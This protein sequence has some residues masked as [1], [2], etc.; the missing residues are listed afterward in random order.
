MIK[1]CIGILEYFCSVSGI[2]IHIPFCKQQCHYCDF[3]FSTLMSTKNDVLDALVREI[4]MRREFLLGTKIQTIY[5][6]GGTPSVLTSDEINRLF[7]EI[8]T[9]FD[10]SQLDEVTIEANPDDLSI[11]KIS[12]LK[13]TPVNRFSIGV[14]SFQQKDLIYMNRA[15]SVNQAF[16][17]IKSVQDA[18]WKNITIDLIYGTPTLSHELWQKNLRYVVDLNIPHLSAYGLT[19]EEKTPLYHSI[20]S[21]KEKDID[22]KKSAEQFEFLMDFMPKYGWEQYEISNF[23]KVGF[24]AKHNGSYWKDE[25]YLGIGPSAHSFDGTKRWWNIANNSLYVK[26]I[27]NNSLNIEFENLSEGQRFNEYIMTALRTK[28]GCNLTYMNSRF[29]ALF[30]TFFNKSV[31]K[32]VKSKNII[33]NGDIFCLTKKGKLLADQIA[34]D[35]FCLE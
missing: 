16:D 3:H 32:W 25:K 23:A 8:N 26:A 19:V 34:S 13:N 10:L 17:S 12:D 5:F 7:D 6:G 1:Y 29:S 35:L 14:Q 9:H 2:Y 15:H 24:E 11:K 21:G 27:K 33:Q 4:K 30:I 31:K 22:D 28:N 18:G 20:K